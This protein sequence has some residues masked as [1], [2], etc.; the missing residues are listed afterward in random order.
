MSHARAFAIIDGDRNGRQ[1]VAHG[2]NTVTGQLPRYVDHTYGAHETICFEGDPAKSVYEILSGS[3]MLYKLLPD[4]RRQ[5]V[6]MLG[7]G[8]LFGVTADEF[9]DCTAE[10]LL[11]S[12]V[13]SAD[14][15][16]LSASLNA[17]RDLNSCLVRQLQQMHEHAVLL[18]RKSAFERVSSYLMNMV[19][20]RGGNMC[21]GPR[22]GRDD[23]EIVLSMTRQE[24][25]DFLGLTIETVSRVLS[26]MKRR[27]LIRITKQDRIHVRRVCDICKQT[28][29]H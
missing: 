23:W 11:P 24:I 15:S 20:G 29:F 13:R 26:E 6:E 9:Y 10:A 14:T 18:G 21:T 19:P 8:D 28:G 4:G 25:A 7:E 2:D 27:G 5:V 22:E 12:V 17:Q 1:D 16:Q 3:V